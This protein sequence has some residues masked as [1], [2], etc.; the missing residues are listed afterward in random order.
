[1]DEAS[2][3]ADIAIVYWLFSPYQKQN[4]KICRL[5]LNGIGAQFFRFKI[6]FNAV[7]LSPLWFGLVHVWLCCFACLFVYIIIFTMG[8]VYT[9]YM[10]NV[11]LFVLK[12]Y[13]TY[14]VIAL[15]HRKKNQNNC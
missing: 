10:A 4:I 6:Y 8:A 14:F 1:M 9:M 12:Y 7:S 2:G 3:S 5:V 13:H 15:L 11:F